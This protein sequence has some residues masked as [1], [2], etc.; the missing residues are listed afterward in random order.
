[1]GVVALSQS[2]QQYFVLKTRQTISDGHENNALYILEPTT[3]GVKCF[4][5][6][7]R[8]GKIF[9]MASTANACSSSKSWEFF[10]LFWISGI[11]LGNLSVILVNLQRSEFF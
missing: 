10:P 8:L 11:M 9:T 6:F 5:V 4:K 1:M 3:K 7:S 2:S